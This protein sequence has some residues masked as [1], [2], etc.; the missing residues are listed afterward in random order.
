MDCKWDDVLS[1]WEKGEYF[2]YP[3]TLKTR[4]HWNT[5][6]LKNGGKSKF[7]EKFKTNKELPEKQKVK[8]FKDHILKSKNKYVVAFPNLSGDTMLVV[9]M[10]RSGKNYATLK[11]FVDNAPVIQQI[12]LWRKVAEMARKQMNNYGKVWISAHGLGVSYVHIRICNK[13]KYYFDETL[14]KK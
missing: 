14:S 4:F 10:P 11:G 9:P 6:V 8:E 5:S 2:T 13:P 12:E 7:V 3:N 1:K